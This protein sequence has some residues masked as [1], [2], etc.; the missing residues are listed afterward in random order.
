[1][2]HLI[3]NLIVTTMLAEQQ[4]RFAMRSFFEFIVT[5]LRNIPQH[6]N[7]LRYLVLNQFNDIMFYLI[8]G[9]NQKIQ[10]YF[11]EQVKDQFLE[12]VY[13]FLSDQ[14]DM[15]LL[16]LKQVSY[17]V[18]QEQQLLVYRIYD[19]LHE[20]L[21]PAQICKVVS[22]LLQF[23]QHPLM[24]S[25]YYKYRI[26]QYVNTIIRTQFCERTDMKQVMQR[27]D[28]RLRIVDLQ[29]QALYCITKLHVN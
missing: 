15:V 13:A 12:F 29:V 1:M 21:E 9:E 18:I 14:N 7:L 16:T 6:E 19:L 4:H 28:L 8:F 24:T 25:V 26:L 22:L 23:T 27:E 3:K 5:L 10:P 11:Q 20:K 2:I 17:P